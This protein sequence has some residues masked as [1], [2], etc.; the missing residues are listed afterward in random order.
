MEHQQKLYDA[1]RLLEHAQVHNVD[2]EVERDQANEGAG[3][4]RGGRKK[5]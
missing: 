5:T 2:L 3:A 1:T 4:G